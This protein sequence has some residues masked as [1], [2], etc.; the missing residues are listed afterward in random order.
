MTEKEAIKRI[1]DHIEIH[2]AKEPRAIKISEALG[3]ACSAL[4]KQV[5]LPVVIPKKLV[6]PEDIEAYGE[7][8]LGGHCPRCGELV[9]TLWN[10]TFC[11]DCGQKL[12]WKGGE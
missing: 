10:E 3:L 6:S 12:K 4:E 11:G 7:E 1:R 8:A 9:V 2:G 5:A